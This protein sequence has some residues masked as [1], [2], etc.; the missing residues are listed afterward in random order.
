MGSQHTKLLDVAC[1]PADFSAY[2]LDKRPDLEITG[3]DLSSA[4]ITLARLN[5]PSGDFCV[6]DCREISSLKKKFDIFIAGFC[7]PY[8]T[9]E[10]TIKLLGDASNM[11]RNRGLLYLSAMIGEENVFESQSNS[12]GDSVHFWYYSE[13]FLIEE[14]KKKDFSI[15]N[16]EIKPFEKEDGSVTNDIF[17]IAEKL[18]GC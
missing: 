7:I 4:M 12:A 8:L 6:M 1:G 10:E 9:Y 2:L 5:V 11:L 17:I 3:V 16:V 13:R 15:M 18:D 14:L